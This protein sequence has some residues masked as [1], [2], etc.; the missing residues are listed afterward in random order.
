MENQ[1]L[2]DATSQAVEKLQVDSSAIQDEQSKEH[3]KDVRP[4]SNTHEGT[5]DSVVGESELAQRKDESTRDLESGTEQ[6]NIEA[7]SE[8]EV[9]SDG[10][11]D[12][13]GD[14]E[15]K[16]QETDIGNNS[17]QNESVKE[18]DDSRDEIPTEDNNLDPV[19]DGTEIPGMEANRST[20]GRRFDVGPDSPGVVEKAVALKNFV[21]QKSAVAV[22]NVLRRLSGKSDDGV[23]GNSEDEGKD[24]SPEKAVEKSGWNPLNYIKKSSDVDLENIA[25]QRDSITEGS[26]PPIAMKGRIMLYT[27][28]GCQESKEIRL[29]LRT[30]RLG[31]VE[32]NID[33]YPS[34]KVELE[35]ISGST[36]VPKVFFNEILIGGLSELKTLDESGKLDEKIDFLIA[37]APLFETSSPPRSGE[38][39]ESSTGAPDE[40]ALIVHKMKETIA[41]KDRLHKMRRF[42]NCFLGSEAVDFLSEDQYLERHEVSLS[43]A[44]NYLSNT[45]CILCNS[46]LHRI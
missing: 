2:V 5:S 44:A 19:F 12:A 24:V 1:Q 15:P 14:F 25:E 4:E 27:K 40:L 45:R 17:G 3:V 9:N 20:S 29:F 33:V 41:V 28:L 39:D 34:R 31:Y 42:T 26:A 23:V 11:V 13:G 37:E 18:E 35:K 43:N 22:S 38:D 32:I 36:S 21:K 16:S 30:K 46:L 8:T 10:K 6:E 7:K